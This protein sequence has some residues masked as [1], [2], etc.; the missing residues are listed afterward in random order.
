M[1]STWIIW[2]VRGRSFFEMYRSTLQNTF[3]ILPCWSSYFF[4]IP[5]EIS[6]IICQRRLIRKYNLELDYTCRE[7]HRSKF[8]ACRPPKEGRA[9]T[10]WRSIPNCSKVARCDSRQTRIRENPSSPLPS[11]Y[12]EL[13]S[14]SKKRPKN[15]LRTTVREENVCL[16]VA[17]SE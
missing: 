17:S 6:R 9:P 11:M 8:F 16:R 4:T 15:D 5:V 7:G 2:F 3:E 13:S 12:F 1:R 10:S 14:S